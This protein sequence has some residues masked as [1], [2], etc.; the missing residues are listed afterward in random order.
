MINLFVSYHYVG[1]CR[2][3]YDKGF[4]N[5]IL[6]DQGEPIT[7]EALEKLNDALTVEVIDSKGFD[8]AF[9]NIISFKEVGSKDIKRWQCPA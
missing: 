9:V 7:Q 3:Q 6:K 8:S 5:I 1:R 4:D 2:D